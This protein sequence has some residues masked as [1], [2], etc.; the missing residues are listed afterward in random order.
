[1]SKRRSELHVAAN[2]Y[3]LLYL[4]GGILTQLQQMN[5]IRL[6]MDI[7]YRTVTTDMLMSRHSFINY[8]AHMLLIYPGPF[9]ALLGFE[10]HIR[11]YKEN[12]YQLIA[13]IVT[14][15]SSADVVVSY[16]VDHNKTRA[17]TFHR[18]YRSDNKRNKNIACIMLRASGYNL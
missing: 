18:V 1:M 11:A 17:F 14:G 15:Q 2:A 8:I 4:D 13:Y 3:I 9:I 16:A 12:T 7:I 5:T 6:K 10:T